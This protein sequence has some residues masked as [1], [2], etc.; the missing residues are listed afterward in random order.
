MLLAAGAAAP[1]LG[2]GVHGLVVQQRVLV[3]R[4]EPAPGVG[5]PAGKY[6]LQRAKNICIKKQQPEGK[7][8]DNL[9]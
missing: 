4:R 8:F 7:I 3:P 6:L 2:A 1:A 9:K 5:T